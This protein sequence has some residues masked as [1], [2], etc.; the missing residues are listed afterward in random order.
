MAF[1]P[2]SYTDMVLLPGYDGVDG[3]VLYTA[4]KWGDAEDFMY[5]TNLGS[6]ERGAGTRFA[7]D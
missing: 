5:R 3:S 6:P 4:G 2:E 7:R 1:L